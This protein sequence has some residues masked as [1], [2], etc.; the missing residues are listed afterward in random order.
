MA[1]TTNIN[2]GQLIAKIERLTKRVNEQDGL[3]YYLK[4]QVSEL[5]A[6]KGQLNQELAGL[7]N[8]KS[9]I[10][11]INQR[12]N[13]IQFGFSR[14]LDRVE[15][16]EKTGTLEEGVRS[17][18]PTATAFG[19][20]HFGVKS[21]DG[22]IGDGSIDIE[23]NPLAVLNSGPNRR[24]RKKRRALD[25][26]DRPVPVTVGEN[27]SQE[28]IAQMEAMLAKVG[29][30]SFI[31]SWPSPYNHQDK[32]SIPQIHLLREGTTQTSPNYAQNEGYADP[33]RLAGKIDR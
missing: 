31:P 32:R 17:T 21:V 23:G 22:L 33:K 24:G 12:L 16:L 13:T 25:R 30:Y 11:T 15:V 7:T 18:N 1:T 5:D 8:A 29:A 3:I 6:K 2:M 20:D 9:A 4:E 28:D 27:G 19:E 14:I 10:K 26:D